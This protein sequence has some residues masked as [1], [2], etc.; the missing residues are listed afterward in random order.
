MARPRG[1]I[2]LA[3]EAA[4]RE[5]RGGATWRE[6]AARSGVGTL[7]ARATMRTMA[8]CGDAEILG[9]VRVPGT[10]RKAVLY[11]PPAARTV[12][13]PGP[14]DHLRAVMCAWVR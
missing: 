2:R 14:D 12:D 11:G 9:H 4:L 5:T 13:G 10:N 7:A 1:V 6:L 3:L 8:R